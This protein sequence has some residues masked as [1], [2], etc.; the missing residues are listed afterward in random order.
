MDIDR[1]CYAVSS[2]AEL[3]KL[4][5]YVSQVDPKTVRLKRIIWPYR[6]RSQLQCALTNC[7]A[8]HKEGVLVELEDGT[9]SNIGHVCGGHRDKFSTKFHDELQKFSESRLRDEMMPLLLDRAKLE[10]IE[11][12]ARNAYM[13]GKKWLS[14]M[15]AFERIHPQISVEVSRRYK[16]GES[17]VVT[18][19]V[20]RNED[21]I[22][23]VVASGLFRTADAARY[24]EV[25]QGVLLGTTIFALTDKAV[26]SLWRRA[27]ALLSVDPQVLNVSA[28]LRLFNEA[29]SLPN[30]AR[31]VLRQCAA[32]KDFFAATNLALMAQLS[33][34]R[35]GG[36]NLLK[37]TV[38]ML[39]AQCVMKSAQARGSIGFTKPL[40]K[41]QREHFRRAERQKLGR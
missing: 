36:T 33:K 15:Q 39:D 31:E 16:M 41:K 27:D 37:L 2:P 11:Q 35:G 12:V 24:K 30:E 18:S 21:E 3:R 13:E 17:M 5:G 1:L 19:V 29:H 25:Q 40:S 20:R 38:E 7:R 14:R 26:A 22:E 10:S 28:L 23:D 34:T 32:G 4:P 6:F 9:I 8:H